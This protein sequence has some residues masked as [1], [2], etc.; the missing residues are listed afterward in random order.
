MILRYCKN[1]VNVKIDRD[2]EIIKQFCKK[3]KKR[4]TR[5]IDNSNERDIKLYGKKKLH[6]IDAGKS[7]LA[8]NLIK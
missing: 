1:N 4:K 7:F 2:N 8:N 6:L 3:R 5:F